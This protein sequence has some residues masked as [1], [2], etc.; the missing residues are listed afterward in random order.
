M[1][2]KDAA[3]GYISGHQAGWKNPKHRAQWITTL[4]KYADPV[5]G[6]LSVAD[7]E[8]AH[9]L[10]ILEPMWITK[11]TTAK[12]LRGRI[13][14]VLDWAAAHGHRSHADPARWKGFLDK[15]LAPPDKV[16]KVVH[17]RALS[18]SELGAFMKSLRRIDGMGAKALEI[19]AISL[20]AATTSLPFLAMNVV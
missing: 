8:L 3:A 14:P 10:A 1:T 11:T 18:A 5:I 17:H 13:E 9:I 19:A 7:I 12:R 20:I 15:L 6:D 2:F 16:R 4:G